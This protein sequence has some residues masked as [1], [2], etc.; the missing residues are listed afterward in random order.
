MALLH[1]SD[2]QLLD[3]YDSVFDGTEID[4]KTKPG[5]AH[6]KALRAIYDRGVKDAE[7]AAAKRR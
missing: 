6:I 1:P 3:W 4:Q 5:I 2:K 7:T